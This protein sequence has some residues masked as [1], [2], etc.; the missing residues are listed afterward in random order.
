[1]K[2]VA[3]AEHKS[4]KGAPRDAILMMFYVPLC[5]SPKRAHWKVN[6]ES[7]DRNALVAALYFL[8]VCSC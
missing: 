8:I 3:N 7:L 6:S 2:K 1:M 5:G 4:V